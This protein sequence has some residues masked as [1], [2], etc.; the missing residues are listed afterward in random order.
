[1]PRRQ[2]DPEEVVRTQMEGL[3]RVVRNMLVDNQNMRPGAD[4]E[5]SYYARETPRTA[6]FLARRL[7]SLAGHVLDRIETVTEIVAVMAAD[8][9]VPGLARIH[10]GV[11]HER[12][13]RVSEHDD[14]TWRVAIEV[15]HAFHDGDDVEAF[16]PDEAAALAAV[17]EFSKTGEIPEVLRNPPSPPV[18]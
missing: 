3:A 18:P 12:N 7:P 2:P 1:M 11:I 14:G 5:P 17:R 9:E 10:A 8:P 15:P 4:G 6:D 13:V 16:M